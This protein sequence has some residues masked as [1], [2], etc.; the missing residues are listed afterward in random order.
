MDGMGW[1]NISSRVA[2]GP[3]Y[4]TALLRV[5]IVKMG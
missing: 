3:N 5:V 4:Q 2:A 1:G